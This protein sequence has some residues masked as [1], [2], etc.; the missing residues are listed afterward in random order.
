MGV[1]TLHRR[2]G[3]QDV[4]VG[5]CISVLK[6]QNAKSHRR[7]GNSEGEVAKLHRSVGNQELGDSKLFWRFGNSIIRDKQSL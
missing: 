5:K 2:V 6:I 1:G 4:G 3:E 7:V